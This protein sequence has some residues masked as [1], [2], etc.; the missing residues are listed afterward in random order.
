MRELAAITAANTLELAPQSL[1]ETEYFTSLADWHLHLFGPLLP[2]K[3]N[4]QFEGFLGRTAENRARHAAK[5]GDAEKLADI[6]AAGTEILNTKDE[7]GWQLIHDA[8]HGGHKA[9][10][11]LLVKHGANI[12]ERT[13]NGTGGTPLWWAKQKHGKDHPV[14]AFL[15]S[16][17]AVNIG[18]EV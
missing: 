12:N 8:S 9:V 13:N 7:N 16:M 2:E 6:L 17:G 14:V 18:P 10:V 11:D 4:R 1:D 3:A 5:V 15:T